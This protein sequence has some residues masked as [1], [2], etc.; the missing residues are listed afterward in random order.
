MSVIQPA[1]EARRLAQFGPLGQSARFGAGCYIEM[2]LSYH[3]PHEHGFI[4]KWK[5]ILAE[6]WAVAGPFFHELTLDHVLTSAYVTYNFLNRR[7]KCSK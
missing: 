3:Q 4:G 5:L 7:E 6:E 1:R 2:T